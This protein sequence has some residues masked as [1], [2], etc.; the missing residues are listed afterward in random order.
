EMHANIRGNVQGVGFRAT[1]KA[2][3]EQLHL[4]G[5]VENLPDGSVA[6]CAQGP[7]K[8]LDR[9]IEELRKAFAEGNMAHVSLAFH[10]I[11]TPCANF[12]I[13]SRA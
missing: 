12:Q 5:Y 13:R 9:L 8:Q 1:T 3:A 4:T 11:A 10:E 6:I 7:R 2:I